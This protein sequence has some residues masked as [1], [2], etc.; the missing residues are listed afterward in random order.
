MEQAGNQQVIPRF[1]AY[2][3]WTAL[4]FIFVGKVAFCLA[5]RIPLRG[6][7]LAIASRLGKWVLG[8]ASH[9]YFPKQ[10]EVDTSFRIVSQLCH[11]DV[12]MWLWAYATWCWSSQRYS[13]VTILED[14][15][16]TEDDISLLKK[17]PHLKI[18][19]RT[20]ADERV[21]AYYQNFP[22]V[23]AY[24]DR[25]VMAPKITDV[26]A[27]CEPEDTVFLFD[28]DLCFFE[29]PV[30]LLDCL[31]KMERFIYT[32]D[33]SVGYAA[34]EELVRLQ[35]N[36]PE[37]FCAGLCGFKAG[38]FSAE[39]VNNL[40]V[41]LE[42]LPVLPVVYEDQILYTILAGK[43]GHYALPREYSNMPL[44]R[45]ERIHLVMKHYHSYNKLFFTLEGLWLLFR[46]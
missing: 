3:R 34:V 6:P 32:H 35:K 23:L 39:Q 17:I 10:G 14:G 46:K 19:P 26:L 13:P 22:R 11:R 27:E 18:I 24:R 42:K 31:R 5:Y 16:L 21:R 33:G 44:D 1:P 8:F 4:L 29:K 9:L 41:E 20:K 28:A 45:P 36:I 30:E 7:L 40:C 38:W 25:F 15:S 12:P 2:L 43:S 37:G